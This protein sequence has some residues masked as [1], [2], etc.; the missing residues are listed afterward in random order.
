MLCK[1]HLHELRGPTD[2]I[3]T[4]CRPC[5]D[6]R[7][8][9]RDDRRKL[10]MS[11]LRQMET[12]GIKESDLRETDGFAIGLR[13]ASIADDD[14]LAAIEQRHP[15]LVGKLRNQLARIDTGTDAFVT[16]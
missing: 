12:A 5:Y 6:N 8:H 15:A 9:R 14:E 1:N 3:G 13:W 10:A 2:V 7:Q 16:H 11:L 4:E